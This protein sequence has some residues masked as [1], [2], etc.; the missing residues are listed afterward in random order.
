MK[1]LNEKVFFPLWVLVNLETRSSKQMW[2]FAVFFE[3]ENWKPWKQAKGFTKNQKYSFRVPE[4]FWYHKKVK[5]RQKHTQ[6][7]FLI[8]IVRQQKKQ[9]KVSLRW[10]LQVLVPKI[11]FWVVGSKNL[12]GRKSYRIY[13]TPISIM[14]RFGSQLNTVEFT[15][16]WVSGLF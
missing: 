2:F 16:L 9:I 6:A 5:N 14:S 1:Y 13:L 11:C 8:S 4:S 10:D 3:F 15:I 12:S 7:S